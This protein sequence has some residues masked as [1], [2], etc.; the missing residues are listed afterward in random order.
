M[1]P[2]NVAILTVLGLLGCAIYA[3]ACYAVTV[4]ADW[5]FTAGRGWL[6]GN[7]GAGDVLAIGVLA[8]GVLALV[9]LAL[10]EVRR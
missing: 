10:S 3:V 7:P 8:I 4:A 2:R 6:A 5:L 9:A 1:T